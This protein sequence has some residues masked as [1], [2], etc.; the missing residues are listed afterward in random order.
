MNYVAKRILTLII[1]LFIVSLLAFLAFQIISDPAVAILGTN[2]TEE[3][4]EALREEM[5]LNRPFFVQYGD[6]LVNFLQGDF[7]TSYS[8]HMAVSDLVAQK[9]PITA[10]LTLLS[11]LIMIAVSFP[12][13]VLCAKREGGR[14]DRFFTVLGQVCMS[15]PAFLLGVAFTYLF[16]VLLKL[17][18]PGKFVA[19]SE[20]PGQY[21]LY[22]S[23]AAL[24]IAIPRIAMT[25]KMLRSSI[26]QQMDQ[27]Y[28]RTAYSWGNSR[29]M[30]LRRHALRNA[31]IPAITF[32]ATS[33]AEI[34]ASCIIVEQV[35]TIPGLGVLLLGSITSRD[36]P[37]VLT[38]TMI[39]AFWVIL[40]N[41]I[42]DILYQYADPRI[43]LS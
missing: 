3:S 2:A 25:V 26:L 43:R 36:N 9:L 28:I 30:A 4:V 11:F 8:Y 35:F 1:T 32:I 31:L 17:F 24:A 16:G 38:I 10:V 14:L 39:L 12:L 27:D 37:V 7:G 19:F 40:V 42:A 21:F 29:T 33:M 15:I 23:F 13:S 22:L 6:W 34:V 18:T 41:F 20:S 5:G